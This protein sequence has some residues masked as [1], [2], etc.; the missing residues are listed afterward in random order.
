MLNWT[1]KIN[2]TDYIMA[3]DIN[4]IAHAVEGLEGYELINT[5]NVSEDSS[6]VIIST[7][8]NGNAFSLRK[9]AVSA[10]IKGTDS[11]PSGSTI[12]AILTPNI[13]PIGSIV[14]NTSGGA[15]SVSYSC[16]SGDIQGKSA[17]FHYS[18][19][20][21]SSPNRKNMPLNPLA[22]T[23]DNEIDPITSINLTAMV[24]KV[25]AGSTIDIYG[26][27]S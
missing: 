11:Q 18:F 14:A 4:S 24:G 26:V 5:V 9:F 17:I 16:M 20:Y 12:V 13:F 1:D 19:A 8:I 25:G 10:S 27:R 15:S 2:G 3:E 23:Q 22:F 21:G 7:D 6:S